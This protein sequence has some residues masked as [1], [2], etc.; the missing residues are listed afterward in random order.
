V[1]VKDLMRAPDGWQDTPEQAQLRE[2]VASILAT[3]TPAE[4]VRVASDLIM[5]T[6]DQLLAGMANV[7]RRGAEEARTDMSP[8]E[9]SAASG[10]SRQT[11]SRLLTEA[12][13]L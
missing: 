10:L 12:R 5:V 11:I 3:K 2:C 13:A 7:R 8:A 6:R 1:D 4:A 9:L